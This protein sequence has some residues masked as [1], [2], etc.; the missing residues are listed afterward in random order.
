MYISKMYFTDLEDLAG[1]SFEPPLPE[2]QTLIIAEGFLFQQT[3]LEPYSQ[4]PARQWWL[5]A[6]GHTVRS[7]FSIIN[8]QNIYKTYFFSSDF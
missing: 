1:T 5:N 7:F 4:P 6:A 8:Y 2:D 3:C